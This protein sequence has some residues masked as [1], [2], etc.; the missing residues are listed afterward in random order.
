MISIRAF[1]LSLPRHFFELLTIL[2]FVLLVLYLSSQSV[3]LIYTIPKLSLIALAAIKIIPSV[4]RIMVNI[5]TL[6]LGVPSLDLIYKEFIKLSKI[7]SIK[8]QKKELI[9]EIIFK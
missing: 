1:L 6:K 2:L 9:L 4:N 3:N 8:K 5:Q 7:K